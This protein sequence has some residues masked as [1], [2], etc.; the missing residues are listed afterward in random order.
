[1][2]L[3]FLGD[4]EVEF[5]YVLESVAAVS[6]DEVLGGAGDVGSAAEGHG[7]FAGLGAIYGTQKLERL[8]RRRMDERD[9]RS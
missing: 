5:G 6:V 7:A 3:E 9:Q 8:L 4:F 1:M 2:L